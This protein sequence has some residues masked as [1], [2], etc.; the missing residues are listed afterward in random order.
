MIGDYLFTDEDF[1]LKEADLLSDQQRSYDD[2]SSASNNIIAPIPENANNVNKMS[3]SADEDVNDKGYNV[4]GKDLLYQALDEI[5]SRATSQET[6]D[7]MQSQP[8][9]EHHDYTPN[10]E[11]YETE[12]TDAANKYYKWQITSFCIN[13]KYN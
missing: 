4:Y 3:L 11:V 13:Y 5:G 7:N 6:T 9:T 12:V 1:T 2:N 10:P 8:E